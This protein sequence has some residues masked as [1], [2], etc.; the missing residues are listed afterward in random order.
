MA[1]FLVSI[2]FRGDSDKV[3]VAKRLENSK[4]RAHEVLSNTWM[5]KARDSHSA[6]GMMKWIQT[7][8]GENDRVIIVQIA[9]LTYEN[10]RK[11]TTDWLRRF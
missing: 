1:R 9:D 2:E 3:R 5:V 7:F 6:K 4:G 10:A 8:C 11:G